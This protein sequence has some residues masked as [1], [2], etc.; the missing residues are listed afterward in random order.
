MPTIVIYK[1]SNCYPQQNEG[2]KVAFD[3]LL[4]NTGANHLSDD[5]F[6]KLKIHPDFDGYVARK[7][8]VVQEAK[9]EVEVVPLSEIPANLAAYTTAEAD[10]IIDSTH[11]VDVL[12]RWLS[13]EM[14]STTRKDLTRRI[15]DLGGEL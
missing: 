14:R 7:A 6:A 8:L 4:L 5:Q 2:S 9:A 12:K 3:R 11:D 1:P 15:K 13:T 10:E